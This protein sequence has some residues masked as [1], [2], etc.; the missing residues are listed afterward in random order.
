MCLHFADKD[1][2]ASRLGDLLSHTQL[3]EM[4]QM[5]TETPQADRRTTDV[6][7]LLQAQHKW[8]GRGRA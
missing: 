6:G 4:K 2:E 3:M 1:M 5:E 8:P 7:V